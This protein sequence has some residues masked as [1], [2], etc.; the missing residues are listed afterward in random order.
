MGIDSLVPFGLDAASGGL[1]DVGS[2]RRGNACGCVCP[3]CKTPLIARHGDE[4]EWHFAHRSQKVHSK[5]RK[6]CEYSFGVSVRLMIRQLSKDGLKFRTPRLERS[7]PAFSDSTSE[8]AD[9]GYLVTE[10]ST[11]EL[12][13]VHVGAQFCGV[14]V[15]VLG[16]VQ[17]VPFVLFVTYKGRVLPSSLENP[18]ISKSG[19]IEL[20]INQVHGLFRQERKGRYIDV[21]RKYMEEET[22]GKMWSYHP[23][24]ERL[25]EAAIEKRQSWLQETDAK[26]RERIGSRVGSSEVGLDLLQEPRVEKCLCVMCQNEWEGKSRVCENCKTHLFTT[27]SSRI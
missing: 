17:G 5:T 25:R 9:F 23:R 18:S 11:L 22:N 24:E 6:E 14:S 3:S 4:K 1:V 16:F 8:S 7:L 21:L 26:A 10:E 27:V 12:E 2:V 20:D 19:V 13:N 15:D